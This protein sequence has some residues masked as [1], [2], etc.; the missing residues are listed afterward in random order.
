MIIEGSAKSSL[1]DLTHHGVLGMKWGHRKKAGGAQ[2]HQ[3]RRNLEDLRTARQVAVTTGDSKAV[4]RIDAD[5]KNSP[6]RAIAIRMT[7]GEKAVAILFAAPSG[8]ISLADIVLTS[9][10]SRRIEKKQDDAKK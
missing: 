1:G 3:A 6:D 4:Q 7:R 8:G 10:A 2:I 5:M 9:A